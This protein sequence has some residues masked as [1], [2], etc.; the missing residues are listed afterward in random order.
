MKS[1]KSVGLASALI[2]ALPILSMSAMAQDVPVDQAEE[3]DEIVVTGI[4]WSLLRAQEVKMNAKN[5]VEAISSEELGKFS[6]DSLAESLRRLSGV[7]VEEDTIGSAGDKVSIRGLGS[8]FVVATV[9]G[10]TAWGSGTGEGRDLRSFNF[11]VIPSEVVNEVLVTK[12]P[13]SNTVESGI[14]GSVDVQTLRP[15]E[16]K[17]DKDKNWIAQLETRTDQMNIADKDWGKRFSGAVISKNKNE[18]LGGYLAFNWSDMDGGR[19]RQEVRYRDNRT[20]FI[21]NNNNFMEDAD[22]EFDGATTIRDV[23]FSPDRFNLKRAAVA[24][25]LQYK[26]TDDLNIVADVLYT[27]A[28]RLNRRPNTRFDVDRFIN[29]GPLFAPDAVAIEDGGLGDLP[30]HMTFVDQ[31]GQRC[32]DGGQQVE[33]A[34]CNR[35]G[36]LLAMRDQYRNNFRDAWIGGLNIEY[37]KG[38]WGVSG[39]VYYNTLDTEVH[40]TSIDASTYTLGGTVSVDLRGGNEVIVT[41]DPTDLNTENF[42]ARRLR[43]RQRTNDGEQYGARL[44]FNVDVNRDVIESVEFGGRYNKGDFSYVVSQRASWDDDGDDENA[45]NA[46][47]YGQGF[48]DSVFGVALPVFDLGAAG[49]YLAAGGYLPDVN[50]GSDFGP[51]TAGIVSEYLRLDGPS[52]R[53]LTEECSEL[54]N[55]FKVDE[56]TFNA[57]A[58]ANLGWEMGKTPVSATVGFRMVRTQNSSTGVVVSVNDD[59]DE[60]VPD[61]SDL[62]T[63][64]GSFTKVLPSVNVR[65]DISNSFQLRLAAS[66]SLSRPDL[67]DLTPRF[68]ISTSDGEDNIFEPAVDCDESGGCS[69]R[70]GN[71]NLDPYTAWNYDLTAIWSMPTEGFLAASLYHKDISGFIFDQVSDPI[72]L[73]GFTGGLFSVVQPENASS[74]SVTGF[75]VALHQPF[76]FLPEPLDGFGAQVNYSYTDSNFSADLPAAVAAVFGDF[77]LPGASPHN[78]NGVLYY[79]KDRFSARVAYVYRD[80]YFSSF[81]GGAEGSPRFFAAEE[82]ISASASFDIT[83]NFQIRVQGANLN[84]DGR[85]EFTS[86]ETQ[87]TRFTSRPRTYSISLRAKF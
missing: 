59:G 47:M 16:A 21:D 82:S 26:P 34:S 63:T 78:M 72:T 17:F 69:V 28:D 45:F 27:K 80:D 19:D 39:D 2:V 41:Y 4:R 40:E 56:E 67:F 50:G 11:S 20:F 42:E 60:I 3:V 13:V 86:F 8:Q 38:S 87:T 22:E 44:D 18:T 83:D 76:T 66:Q 1:V 65:A 36:R 74:A 25:A 31:T 64:K 29:R 52:D 49:D 81:N 15:L 51:C 32:I 61:P 6:D 30:F 79:E 58:A 48:H 53:L 24:A 75:E 73:P 62:T 85:T 57:Y 33:D 54:G 9:N 55:S 46:A 84:E 10:R 43:I 7:Q 12:T 77:S 37:D 14:G 23:S 71:P 68:R 35:N 5:I 70:R